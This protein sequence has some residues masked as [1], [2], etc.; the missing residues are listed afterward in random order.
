MQVGD[1][2]GE[3]KKATRYYY[4]K[5]IRH[6]EADNSRLRAYRDTVTEIYDAFQRVLDDDKNSIRISWL[7][8]KFRWLLK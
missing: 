7:L 5:R 6:L 1:K 4:E 8:T 3:M 2:E